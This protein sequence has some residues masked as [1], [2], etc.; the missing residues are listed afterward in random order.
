MKITKL[1]INSWRNFENVELDIPVE[2]TLVALIGENG[3][4]K[5]S[6]LDV[7]NS[8]AHRLGL[9]AGVDIPRDDP[10]NDDHDFHIDV[11]IN[12]NER[13]LLPEAQII[14][15]REQGIEF[16]G[17]ISMTSKKTASTHSNRIFLTSYPGHA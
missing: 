17:K 9:S 3:V 2:A 4:G 11:V 15:Y 12:R 10:F 16:D 1:R 5:S 14:Y 6:L 8:V 13:N 7:V